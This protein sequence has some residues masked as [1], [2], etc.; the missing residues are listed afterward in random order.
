MLFSRIILFAFNI[1][2]IF[3]IILIIELLFKGKE[4]ITKPLAFFG[5]YSLEIYLVHVAIRKII[6]S[7]GYPSYKFGYYFLFIIVSIVVSILF[8]MLIKKVLRIKK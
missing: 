5:K 7:Y 6:K 8:N 1:S 2:I 4:T 3:F